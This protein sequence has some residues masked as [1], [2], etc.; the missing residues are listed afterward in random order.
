MAKGVK[1]L[2]ESLR[3]SEARYRSVIEA[4]AEGVLIIGKDGRI[5]ECNLSAERILDR[6]AEAILGR[7][8]SVVSRTAIKE[9]GR[10]HP[11]AECPAIR[12]LARPLER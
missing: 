5:L 4:M 2:T 1:Q 8:G 11:V 7:K 3:A 9:D 6:K 12:C 10:R